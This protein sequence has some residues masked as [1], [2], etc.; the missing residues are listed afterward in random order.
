MN[1]T[2]KT[3]KDSTLTEDERRFWALVSNFGFSVQLYVD[4]LEHHREDGVFLAD[5]V[6]YSE[7]ETP[8]GV[9]ACEGVTL[10][11]VPDDFDT[12]FNIEIHVPIAVLRHADWSVGPA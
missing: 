7:K 1:K 12:V 10:K 3:D 5:G 2:L 8:G 6:Y 4:F 11:W 9:V